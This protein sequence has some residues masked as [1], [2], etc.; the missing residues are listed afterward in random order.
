MPLINRTMAMTMIPT[1]NQIAHKSSCRYK[2]AHPD[3][4]E[5]CTLSPL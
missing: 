3:F 2:S 5:A 4:A 1:P